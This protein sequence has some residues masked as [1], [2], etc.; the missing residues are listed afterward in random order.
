[1][2]RTRTSAAHP[3]SLQPGGTLLSW[4]TAIGPVSI[5]IRRKSFFAV[6]NSHIHHAIV[7]NHH[8][9][10]FCRNPFI[11]VEE[12]PTH[13]LAVENTPSRLLPPLRSTLTV[14][15]CVF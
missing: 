11:P 15:P 1:M 2:F 4:K 14:I 8:T 12:W 13:C 3:A 10:A 7:E 9:T 5:C 6:E